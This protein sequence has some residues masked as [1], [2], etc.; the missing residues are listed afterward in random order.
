ME[1]R[2]SHYIRRVKAHEITKSRW[3]VQ[4][5]WNLVDTAPQLAL[6]S[7]A[8]EA[9]VTC[10]TFLE[11]L[12][13]SDSGRAIYG[14]NTGFGDLAHTRVGAEDLST[15]QRNLLVSHACGVGEDVPDEVVRAMMV[16]KVK[17]LCQGHSGVRL[18]TVERLVALWNAD[19]LPVVP[20]QGSLGASGDLAPLSHLVLPLIGEGMLHVDGIAVPTAD[21]LLAK[22]WSPLSLGAKEGLALINGTQLMLGYGV[23]A[24]QRLERI[25]DWADALCAWSL[26]AWQGRIEPFDEDIHRIRNQAGAAAVARNVVD[27]LAGSEWQRQPRHQVQDPYSFRCTP[28]VHGASRNSLRS[29]REVFENEINA[30]TDNPLIF[31]ASGKVLSGGNFHGQ[32]LALVLES[33]AL[34]AHEWGSI[35]ERRTFKLLSGKQGLPAFLTPNPGLNSGFMIPQYTAASLVSQSKQLCMPSAADTIDS[36]NGQEDHVSMGANSA[37]KLWRILDNVEQVLAVECITAAQACDLRGTTGMAPALEGLQRSLR[38]V[39]PFLETDAFMQPLM[40]TARDWMFSQEL[41]ANS[42]SGH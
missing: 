24:L 26:E 41:S 32:P 29:A 5:V 27:W 33:L 39:I 22:G 30:V 15:L 28:Q 38:R 11:H 19:L 7:D 10:R 21:V 23:M 8:R 3:D 4:T 1:R 18:E 16:L 35:S 9:V 42:A 17:A 2:Q 13:S 37:L 31:P 40:L 6:G 20:S 36:S 12:L 14:V 34:A 25:A